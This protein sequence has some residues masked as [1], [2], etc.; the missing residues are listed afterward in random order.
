MGNKLSSDLD[1]VT[2]ICFNIN[3]LHS[4]FY[5][6][7]LGHRKIKFTKKNIVINNI[8]FLYK[9]LLYKFKNSKFT[10]FYGFNQSLQ[11]TCHKSIE[12]YK[13]FKEINTINEFF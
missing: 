6:I 11:F 12:L 9:D 7:K 8:P 10:L 2:P 3:I 5:Y 13:T 4:D 1:E